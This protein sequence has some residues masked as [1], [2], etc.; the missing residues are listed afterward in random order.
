MKRAPLE[1]GLLQ[2]FR[3]AVG[4][5]LILLAVSFFL[6]RVQ[7]QPRLARYPLLG[8]VESILLLIYLSWPSLRDR[9]RRAYLPVA[10][11][12]ASVGPILEHALTIGFR[13][14]G[15]VPA[16]TA[17]TDA[18]QLILVLFVPLILTSWQYDFK[19]VL[20]MCIGT[21]ALD[22]VVAVPLYLIARSPLGGLA[23]LVLLR[24]LLFVPVGYLVVRLMRAQ[25]ARH[26]ALT[27][28][29]AQLARYAATLEQLAVSRE[30][31]RLARELHDTL[32]H[33]LSAV[34]VQLEAAS[35]LW[36][37]DPATARQMV[38][39]SL[40]TTRAGLGE[41]RRAIQALRASPLEDL[42]LALAVRNLAESVAA[43]AGLSLDVQIADHLGGLAAEVEQCVYRI[44]AE[45]L[46]NVARHADAHH[47]RVRLDRDGGRLTLVVADDGRGFD[48]GAGVP[49]GHFG[50]AG[51]RERAEM[52][53]GDLTLVSQAGQGTTVRLVVEA[54]G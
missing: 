47:L 39:R 40:E 25:R 27:R 4:V 42:G 35:A 51:M 30:R 12:V 54:A 8:I 53:G 21:A 14:R 9:L 28:A 15:G 36:D 13:L 49:E 32:A 10:L 11:V 5:R 37:S 43:R 41:A 34:A 6:Q 19:A 26:Q 31:N 46:S 33:G 48:P 7:A 3:L 16:R 1:P 52:I 20:V 45:A 23:T 24:T 22:L 38:E 2:V 29:H 44:A 50:L 18:W 17:A